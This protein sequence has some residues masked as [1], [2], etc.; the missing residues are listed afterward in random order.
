MHFLLSSILLL[1]I[2]HQTGARAFSMG[3]QYMNMTTS[4]SSACNATCEYFNT[5]N[6]NCNT[7]HCACTTKYVQAQGDC[8]LCFF[9]TPE[10]HA[11]VQFLLNEEVTQCQS[12]GLSVS[13]SLN[14]SRSAET[15]VKIFDREGADLRR[16]QVVFLSLQ[17]VGGHIGLPVILIYVL[18]SRRVRRD[19]TFLNFCVTW[20]LSSIA[21][22]LSLY[23]GTKGNTI[24]NPLGEIAQNNCLAQMAL[25][26]GAQL[27][28]ACSTLSL[29]IRLWLGLR[30]VLH[31]N[32][33][34]TQKITTNWINAGLLIAPYLL[35]VTG[36]IASILMGPGLIDA[37]SSL[38]PSGGA[39]PTSF[40]CTVATP[41]AFVAVA[42]GITLALV[43]MSIGFSGN[44][45]SI[46]YRH[47][48]LSRNMK[49]QSPLSPLCMVRVVFFTAYQIVAAI[50][51]GTII[52][53]LPEIDNFSSNAS[54]WM[55]FKDAPLLTGYFPVWINMLQAATPLVAALVFGINKELLTTIMNSVMFWRRSVSTNSQGLTIISLDRDRY[56]NTH[57]EGDGSMENDIIVVMVETS[58]GSL[59]GIHNHV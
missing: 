55:T 48:G 24:F 45:I 5:M 23:R 50:A 31:G 52:G 17:I 58:K 57:I 34:Q 47:R 56:I 6:N 10:D 40:Y 41:Q 49:T 32:E 20:I 8:L 33:S 30:A 13:F 26:E 12:E 35:F 19:P 54:L 25:T 9:S 42:Y 3:P 22:S 2:Y 1:L 59:H 37:R 4:L 27:M 11:I 28:T 43:L 15:F 7:P 44:V 38:G 29:N 39:I 46:L 14:L 53:R 36:A 21:F 16:N 18:C 51:D